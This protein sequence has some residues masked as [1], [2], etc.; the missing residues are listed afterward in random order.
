[1]R[2]GGKGRVH[3]TA[4]R[5]QGRGVRKWEWAEECSWAAAKGMAVSGARTGRRRTAS[6]VMRWAFL[7]VTVRTTCIPGKRK[8]PPSLL[9]ARESCRL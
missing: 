1:M 9:A 6:M 2:D 5:G 4:G 3:V 7:R 8:P